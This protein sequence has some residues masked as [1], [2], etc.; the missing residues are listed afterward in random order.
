[1]TAGDRPDVP[2]AAVRLV[3]IRSEELSVGE[4]LAAM[5]DAG[6]GGTTMFVGTVRDEDAGRPVTSLDYSAHPRAE[7]TMRRVAAEVAAA[8]PV[9]ALA[10]VHRTGHLLV[11]DAAVVVAVACG[12]RG[13]AFAASRELIDRIKAEVPIW[14][15]QQFGDGTSAWVGLDC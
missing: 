9:I 14:K 3:G 13:D 7:A 4:V 1:V 6:A 11:G 5:A 15:E 12:H 10:A 8:H 2:R